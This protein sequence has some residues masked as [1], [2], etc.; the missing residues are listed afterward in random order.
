MIL[1]CLFFSPVIRATNV[2][3]LLQ[4]KILG[5][6]FLRIYVCLCKRWWQGEVLNRDT[7]ISALN[8]CFWVDKISARRN[9]FCMS[10]SSGR[11]CTN[12]SVSAYIY[13]SLSFFYIYLQH[14]FPFS[15]DKFWWISGYIS[16][17][18]CWRNWLENACFASFWMLTCIF[19]LFI[20]KY[21][22]SIK[23]AIP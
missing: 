3:L 4:Q 9:R 13:I 20:F 5:E 23:K 1:N 22:W 14:N 8:S 12:Q 2:D 7:S 21:N 10:T 17:G 19:S 18:F 11:M 6:L 16:L 15:E